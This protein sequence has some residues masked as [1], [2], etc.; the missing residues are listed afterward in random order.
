MI[1]RMYT[2]V[3]MWSPLDMRRDARRSIDDLGT[4]ID[5]NLATLAAAPPMDIEVDTRAHHEPGRSRY[6]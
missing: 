1:G 2:I 5:T 4:R 3:L 6:Y